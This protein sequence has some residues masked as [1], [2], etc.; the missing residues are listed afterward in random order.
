MRINPSAREEISDV[1]RCEPYVYA[2]MIAGKDAA[3]PGEAKNSWLSGSAAWNLVAITQ[4]ILGIRP[5]YEGLRIDPHVPSDWGEFQVIRRFRGAAYEIKVTKPRGAQARVTEIVVDGRPI[6][7][8][9]VPP[10]PAGSTVRVE[11]SAG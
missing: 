9:L 11:V 3:A 2:Q 7:G 4:H 8:N 5:E 1:H 6:D 10:A